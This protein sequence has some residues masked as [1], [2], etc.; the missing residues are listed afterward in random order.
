MVT[1]ARSIP[2]GRL[3]PHGDPLGGYLEAVLEAAGTHAE[4]AREEAAAVA[5]ALVA[6]GRAGTQRETEAISAAFGRAA[7]TRPAAI[8]VLT[9]P[10]AVLPR[11]LAD[12]SWP[13]A[14]RYYLATMDLAHAI[15]ALGLYPTVAAL[16][17]IARL[18]TVLL[19]AI[20]AAGARPGEQHLD[21]ERPGTRREPGRD[22]ATSDVE[23]LLVELDALV[24]LQAVKDEVR[25]VTDRLVVDQHRREVALPVPDA[26]RHL[27][28]TGNPGTGKS[29]VARLVGRIYAA[30]GV[31]P[32]G[33]LVETGREG[34]VAGYVGQTAA[35]VEQ[36]FDEAEGGLLLVDE[37]YSLVR[38]GQRDFGR[39]AVDTLLKLA[40]DRRDRVVVILA[41]YPDEMERL[42]DINPGMR[43]RFPRIVHFPDY[44]TDELCHI[45]GAIASEGGYRLTPA[46]LSVL[47]DG[48]DAAARHRGFGNGRLARNIIE[49]A[50]DHQAT[51]LAD[52]IRGGRS[53]SRVVLSRLRKIDLDGALARVGGA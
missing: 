31:I 3:R 5:H 21:T 47:R 27:V 1:P 49:G 34:L 50:V 37:A 23:Q 52:T 38:G 28:F 6:A 25:R 36:R 9:A 2:T 14:W 12:G 17:R 32:E 42:L 45:A 22:E 11:L 53:P 40:E 10:D 43:S 4:Q 16:D 35:R 39:E 26:S 29:T 44:T 24:G 13:A 8:E 20:D 51:R 7:M 18:R 15:V 41:G 19:T 48:I 33:H 30:L 46:A